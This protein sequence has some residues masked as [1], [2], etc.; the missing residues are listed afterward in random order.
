ME[1]I[2]EEP[3]KQGPS[4]GRIAFWVVLTVTVLTGGCTAAIVAAAPD[5]AEHKRYEACA[6]EVGRQTPAAMWKHSDSVPGYV[7]EAT[8]RT[9][10]GIIGSCMEDLEQSGH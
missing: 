1:E 5:G 8:D 9:R 3:S 4:A 10:L 2:T 6:A 7:N